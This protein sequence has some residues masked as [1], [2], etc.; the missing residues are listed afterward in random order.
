MT[1]L[2]DILRMGWWHP[3]TR[4]LV[5]R[6]V[7]AEI[8]LAAGGIWDPRALEFEVRLRNKD[9][10][11]TRDLSNYRNMWNGKHAPDKATLMEAVRA[12]PSA[13]V[14]LWAEHP[15]FY[16]LDKPKRN[17]AD[18]REAAIFYALDSISGPLRALLWKADLSYE[19]WTGRRLHAL[20]HSRVTE[21]LSD[22]SFDA[23]PALPKL[24]V[25]TALAKYVMARDDNK[26]FIRASQL[27]NT[28]FVEAIATTPN[29]YI[30]WRQ[31]QSIFVSQLW[32]ASNGLTVRDLQLPL[33]HLQ[34][35]TTI[36]R[37]A[38]L[39]KLPEYL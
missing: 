3:D 10:R 22:A 6:A 4:G 1:A 34:Q 33:D 13:Q 5:A 20:E 7:F 16:L 37:L 17:A 14:A 28:Y 30:Q 26:S 2:P 39:S 8:A 31:L 29:L 18:A 32:V 23:L 11:G 21:I 24:T 38:D 25:A 12:Y 35:V 15:L 27:T 36:A 19:S 9:S